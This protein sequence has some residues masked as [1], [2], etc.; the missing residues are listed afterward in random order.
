MNYLK[1][2]SQ[3]FSRAMLIASI[4]L[5]LGLLPLE[6]LAVEETVEQLAVLVSSASS[7]IAIAIRPAP[8][9]PITG[10]GKNGQKITV[11][12]QVGDYLAFDDPNATWCHIRLEEKPNTEGWVEGKFVSLLEK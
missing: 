1:I 9:Q 11:F 2:Y 3:A 4:V 7:P 8:N 6:S 5:L 10:Y 12:E